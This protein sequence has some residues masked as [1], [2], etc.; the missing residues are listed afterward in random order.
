M[1]R[2]PTRTVI[3]VGVLATANWLGCG[4]PAP[5]AVTAPPT[6]TAPREPVGFKLTKSRSN[7]R[8]GSGTDH[9]IAFTLDPDRQVALLD[10]TVGDWLN[11]RVDDREGWIYSALLKPRPQDRWT[12]AFDLIREDLNAM[13]FVSGFWSEEDQLRVGI[14]QS[15]QNLSSSAKT[16]AVNAIA[17]PWALAAG[18]LGF[19]ETPQVACVTNTGALLATWHFFWGVKILH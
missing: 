19:E 17:R 8:S 5:P 3:T 15:W 13:P 2:I 9:A 4:P 14:K 1:F 12:G 7:I 6:A 16:D 10:S 18:R 11:I